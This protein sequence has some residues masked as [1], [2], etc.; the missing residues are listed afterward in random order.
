MHNII[1]NE[2][3]KF[4]MDLSANSLCATIDLSIW[5]HSV[6]LSGAIIVDYY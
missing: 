2:V 4:S 3:L 5:C 6:L 1:E